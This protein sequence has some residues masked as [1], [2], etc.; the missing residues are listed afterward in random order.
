HHVIHWADGGP[1]NLHNLRLLCRRHHRAEHE[2]RAAARPPPT[3]T[4]A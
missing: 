4:A 1:T 3:R 2:G